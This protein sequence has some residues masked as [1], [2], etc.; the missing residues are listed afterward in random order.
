MTISNYC[1]AALCL[2]LG[3]LLG[4]CAVLDHLPTCYFKPYGDGSPFNVYDGPSP[5]DREILDMVDSGLYPV[6]A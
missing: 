1:Q 4:A 2:M 6:L 3:L 5:I